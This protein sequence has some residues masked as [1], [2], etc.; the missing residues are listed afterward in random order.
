MLYKA[1]DFMRR[2]EQEQRSY[3]RQVDWLLQDDSPLLR[4][5]GIYQ[6]DYPPKA[7]QSISDYCFRI[8]ILEDS[9]L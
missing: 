8:P 4:M 2:K 5:A 6:E 9:N 1:R 7:D 3:S